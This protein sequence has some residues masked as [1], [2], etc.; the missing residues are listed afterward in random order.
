MKAMPVKGP[1]AS[2]V[3]RF[4][5]AADDFF[6]SRLR[7]RRPADLLMYLASAAGEHS[8]V[9]LALA[10][11]QGARSGRGWKSLARAALALGAESALVNGLVKLAFR[12]SRPELVP[13]PPLPL[14]RPRTSSFPSGHASAAFFAAALLR[15]KGG[16][17]PLY[18]LVAVIVSVSRL[19][20]RAHHASDVVA[21]AALGAVLGEV[22][23]RRFPL[24]QAIVGEGSPSPLEGQDVA[25]DMT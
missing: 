5:E 7:G 10:G 8:F 23:R 19:H 25:R 24:D 18:Y 20:V 17:W 2:F 12:R 11:L 14:R 9:W 4:D 1:G 13:R 21:G 3:A 22:C 6:E 15:R 16:A